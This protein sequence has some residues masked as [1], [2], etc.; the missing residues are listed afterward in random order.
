MMTYIIVG[1][2]KNNKGCL[3]YACGANKEHAEE[4]LNRMLNNPNDT[5]KY[6]M[7]NHTN[8]RVEA[9]EKKNTWW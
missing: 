6:F 5:D 2:T 4:T 8:F 3:V 9:T 1:D 7:K